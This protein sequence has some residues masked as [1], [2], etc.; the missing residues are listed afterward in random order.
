MPDLRVTAALSTWHV[1]ADVHRLR[2][3]H[4]DLRAER[5]R[6]RRASAWVTSHHLGIDELTTINA[7]ESF[8][9]T[10]LPLWSFSATATTT[11]EGRRGHREPVLLPGDRVELH[12]E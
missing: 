11:Y 10:Y 5:C 7:A 2:G 3:L 9:S 1:H 6:P 4:P 8:T 12:T